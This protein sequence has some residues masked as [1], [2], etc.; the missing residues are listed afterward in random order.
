MLK[1]MVPKDMAENV[2]RAIARQR[3]RSGLT[4]EEVAEWLGVGNEA[5]SRIE[6]GVVVPNI[7]RL[8]EFASIFNCDMVELLAETSPFP[9]DQAKRIKQLLEPLE[10]ADREFIVELVAN[11]A[12]RLGRA[13]ET[14]KDR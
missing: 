14:Q 13:G 5:V 11:L 4:Q 8:A 6:R 7:I 12:A 9:G 2:G 3:A 1:V 10:E